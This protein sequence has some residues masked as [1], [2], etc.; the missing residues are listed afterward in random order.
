MSERLTEANLAAIREHQQMLI[1]P[2]SCRQT[3]RECLRIDMPRLLAEVDALR[4]DRC[5][6][7]AAAV[8]NH[9]RI[10]ELEAENVALSVKLDQCQSDWMAAIEERDEA[11]D[12]VAELRAEVARLQ[13][14][15]EGHCERI[16]AQS[17]LL[18]RRA[19][20]EQA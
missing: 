12:D 14:Q 13:R 7:L 9:K 10:V 15:I 11:L 17:A 5:N 4:F 19:E 2:G 18:S 16:A 20:K 3:M 8:T 1:E 6:Q